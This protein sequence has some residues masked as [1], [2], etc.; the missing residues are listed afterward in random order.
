MNA[1]TLI[2][3]DV[4]LFIRM[5]IIKETNTSSRIEGTRT[6]MD[7]AVLDETAIRP[8]RRDD[9]R[10]VRNYVQAMNSAI[11]ELQRLPLSRRL[12]RKTHET[13][14]AGAEGSVKRLENSVTA[15]TGS[16]V[17]PW[18]MRLLSRPI[19]TNSPTC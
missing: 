16:V 19:M 12:L 10:E 9:W 15:R 5:H 7:E 14:L 1:F 13:L 18:P 4:D 3:P 6:E 2:V 8:E 17:R 11:E